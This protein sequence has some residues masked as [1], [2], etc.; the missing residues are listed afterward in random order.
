MT[1]ISALFLSWVPAE[2]PE[3]TWPAQPQTGVAYG[4]ARDP[5]GALEAGLSL[6]LTLPDGSSQTV[7]ADDNGRLLATG[8]APGDY[9]FSLDQPPYDRLQLP[10]TVSAGAYTRADVALTRTSLTVCV[11]DQE[12]YS[13]PVQL[14]LRRDGATPEAPV[15]A[16]GC[17]TWDRLAP[18]TYGVEVIPDDAETYLPAVLEDIQ[19]ERNQRL[20]R[21]VVLD[22]TPA[23][24]RAQEAQVLGTR[25]YGVGGSAY[26][27]GG[28][29]GRAMGSVSAVRDTEGYVHHGFN[30]WVNVAEDPMS[31]FAADVDTGSYT[32]ARRK[33][34][35]W[36]LPKPDGVRVEEFVNYFDYGY[37]MPRRGPLSVD[38]EAAPHPHDPALHLL[39]IGIQGRALSSEEAARPVHLTLLIDNSGSMRSRDKLGLVKEAMAHLVEN[40]SPDD[41]V[42]IATYAG[43][44]HRVLPPTPARDADT[45]VGALER[46]EAGGSTAMASGMAL[47]YELASAAYVDGHVNR[48]IVLSDGD[49]NVGATSH[50]EILAQISAHAGRGITLSAI[51]FGAGNYQD[52]LM[53]QLADNGDGNYY[54]ID[55]IHEAERV[56]GHALAGTLEV[57]ARDVKLQVRFHPNEVLRYRLL[58]Y[59]NRAVADDAFR[60]DDVDGGEIGAEHQVTALYEIQLNTRTRSRRPMATMLVRT[61]PPGP[62]ARARELRVPLRTDALTP[63][64]PDASADMR[65]S[66]AAAG[67][68]ELLRISPYAAGT[69]FRTQWAVLDTIPDRAPGADQQ[70]DELRELV[71]RADMIVQDLWASP[72]GEVR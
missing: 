69:S 37:T 6:A 17:H 11:D 2:I 7:T 49:A 34:R 59:E 56:F 1:P 16:Q 71:V 30:G 48:V 72:A 14:I 24:L 10:L 31:T 15:A 67:F 3:P 53:E 20:H 50:E 45:I 42:A 47:A 22:Y 43:S 61:K 28:A 29:M 9:V 38:M 63:E 70:R 46:L 35:E 13:A 44:V 25:G 51:G 23:W 26:G 54:Y 32:L 40:L 52:H 66:V 41:T 19:L 18:G 39:R 57:V 8:L 21:D 58:G 68:A 55:G 36:S 27:Y 5:S 60:D 65:L 33:L 62:D 64:L 4:E 12:A